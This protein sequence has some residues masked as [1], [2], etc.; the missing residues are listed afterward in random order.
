[1]PLLTKSVEIHYLYN[2][3]NAQQRK[4][5]PRMWEEKKLLVWEE[6][7]H[8]AGNWEWHMYNICAEW[9]T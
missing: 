4:T 5:D 6:A 2:S 7:K 9:L 1:M 3:D 8:N